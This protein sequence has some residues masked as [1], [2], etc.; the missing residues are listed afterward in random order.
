MDQ[1]LFDL[2]ATLED[3]HWWFVGRR[4]VVRALVE[5][6]L[7]PKQGGT[8]V[9]VGA[10]TGGNAA[11]FADCYRVLALEPSGTAVRLARARHPGVT[12]IQGDDP[13]VL[14]PDP[15]WHSVYLLMD[16]AEHVEDDHLLLSR[17]IGAMRP[18]SHLIVTVPSD[19]SLWSSHDVNFGHHRRYTPARLESTWEGL[20]VEVRLFVDFNRRLA[21]LIRVAR[22]LARA[23]AGTGS[24]RTDLSAPIPVVNRILTTILAGERH[25]MARALQYGPPRPPTG[26]GVSLCALLRRLP[27]EA[28]PRGR[29]AE[30]ASDKEFRR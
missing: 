28:T 19:P 20:P 22:T 2:H 21:P 9:D 18:G 23:L 29:P 7:P 10:G 27:G 1:R 4:R 3:H 16:V 14:R 5:A 6:I 8:I 15:D 30:L 12:F 17:L 13:A 26:R 25:A 11:S 24:G